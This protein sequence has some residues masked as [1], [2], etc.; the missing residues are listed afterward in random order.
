MAMTQYNGKSLRAR[1]I[2]RKSEEF[3]MEE[4]EYYPAA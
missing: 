1:E 2:Y 4:M 3:I